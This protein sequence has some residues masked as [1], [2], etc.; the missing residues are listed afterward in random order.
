MPDTAAAKAA[1][2]RDQAENF[3]KLAAMYQHVGEGHV[4][5][6]DDAEKSAT[7][8][9]QVAK[10]KAPDLGE[11]ERRVRAQYDAFY[12]KL[13]PRTP[14]ADAPTEPVYPPAPIKGSP[15]YPKSSAEKAEGEKPKIKVAAL[16]ADTYRQGFVNG[17][18]R[19]KF[20]GEISRF[21]EEQMDEGFNWGKSDRV[22]LDQ[23]DLAGRGALDEA[24]DV[25]LDVVDMDAAGLGDI[26][27][28]VPT[29]DEK[30]FSGPSHAPKKIGSMKELAQH[31][32]ESEGDFIKEAEARAQKTR[33]KVAED[34]DAEERL[35]DDALKG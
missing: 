20:G 10:D 3:A 1:F 2:Y 8:A 23:V 17:Y 31:L 4:A 26:G 19:G 9:Q 14:K 27:P 21:Y 35:L 15:E 33:P 25:P 7:V 12:K 32:R 24:S 5:E 16:I 34:I 22:K 28:K 30:F 11:V 13:D 6:E 18:L 29:K